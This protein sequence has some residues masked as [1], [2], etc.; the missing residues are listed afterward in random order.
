[1]IYSPDLLGILMKNY[2][3]TSKNLLWIFHFEHIQCKSRFF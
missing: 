3:Q 1:M 2:K